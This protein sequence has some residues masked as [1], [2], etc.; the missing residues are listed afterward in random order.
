MVPLVVSDAGWPPLSTTVTL[1]LH[2]ADLNDNT[3]TPAAKTV[4]V[5]SLQPQKDRVLQ[6]GMQILTTGTPRLDSTPGGNNTPGSRHFY[7]RAT[8]APHTPEGEANVTVY[9]T[10][11]GPRDVIDVTPLTIA[12][13]SY[14]VVKQEGEGQTSILT[15]LMRAVRAWVEEEK[16]ESVGGGMGVRAVSV[17][18]LGGHSTTPLATPTATPPATR[19]W[20]SSPGVA[21]FDHILLYRRMELSQAIGVD[22]RDVGVVTCDEDAHAAVQDI[23][24]EMTPGVA[25]VT[26]QSTVHVATHEGAQKAAHDATLTDTPEAWRCVGGCR[27]GVADGY[28]VVDANTS[29]VVGPWVG[30]RSGCGCGSTATPVKDHMCTHHTC[31]NGGRCIPTSRGIR[32]VCP[33][34]TWGSRCKVVS[35]HFEGGGGGQDTGGV[36][37]GASQVGGWAWVSAIPPCTEVHLSLEVLTQ[38]GTATLLYSGPVTE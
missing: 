18:P 7:R 16:E 30:V 9:V 29:A 13:D 32:C 12:A 35:R 31:L 38:T 11:L 8:M 37:G 4:T 6:R 19:V 20:I 26:T 33:H 14:R 1:T 10:S 27:V 23:T 25:L 21:N 15:R 34:N 22:V 2:V 3:M 5:H 28:S 24:H 17:Q 36:M